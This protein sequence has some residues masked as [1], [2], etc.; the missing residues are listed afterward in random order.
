MDL[1]GWVGV[2]LGGNRDCWCGILMLLYW[3]WGVVLAGLV[4]LISSPYSSE[5]F[6]L[7]GGLVCL[8]GFSMCVCA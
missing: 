8:Q 2:G 3:G 6:A 7:G 4:S 1:V 5:R